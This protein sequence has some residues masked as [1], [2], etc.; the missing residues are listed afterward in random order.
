MER[1]FY[2]TLTGDFTGFINTYKFTLKNIYTS[3]HIK[4]KKK[5]NFHQSVNS[6]KLQSHIQQL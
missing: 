3:K 6:T 4:K 1:K 5:F 2:Q